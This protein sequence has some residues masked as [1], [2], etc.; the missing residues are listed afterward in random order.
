MLGMR[1]I[2]PDFKTVR[3][4]SNQIQNAGSTNQG[5]SSDNWCGYVLTSG[6][7]WSSVNGFWTVPTAR[8]PAFL[9]PVTFD[10][11]DDTGQV[12]TAYVAS[13]WVG[14][15]GYTPVD[16]LQCGMYIIVIPDQQPL[17]YPFYEWAVPNIIGYENNYAYVNQQLMLPNQYPL[18]AGDSLYAA[19]QYSY[20]QPT[21]QTKLAAGGTVFIA[22]FS[23]KWYFSLF[24]KSP[25][26]P[27]IPGG[28]S[29]DGS[30]IE[31]IVEQP[32]YSNA[33]NQWT[34][35]LPDF[36]V[37]NFSGASGLGQN[38]S[39]A[40]V[41]PD[42]IVEYL[43]PNSQGVISA[44]AYPASATPTTTAGVMVIYLPEIT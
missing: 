4:G 39:S 17:Y 24:L 40:Q 18:N 43:N 15:G 13:A 37:I 14:I 11:W 30:S 6:K 5:A 2:I 25:S 19:V 27:N 41:W 20:G 7:P 8:Q 23:A 29:R 32:G 28:A 3:L 16:V 35:S 31:W 22:N 44:L 21:G 1:H 38:T 10:N 26:D 34:G 42:G 12:L 36:G 33:N 9:K